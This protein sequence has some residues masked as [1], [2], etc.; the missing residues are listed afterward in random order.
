MS[1]D[2]FLEA[3]PSSSCHTW[4]FLVQ[5]YNIMALCQEEYVVE[6]SSLKF[7]VE[8]GFDFN[9]QYSCGVGY[10]RGNDKV[11]NSIYFMKD[12][13][14]Y[15]VVPLWILSDKL[16]II[17]LSVMLFLFVNSFVSSGSLIKTVDFKQPNKSK[18]DNYYFNTFLSL[19]IKCFDMHIAMHR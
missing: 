19:K 11:G 4:N 13:L 1:D 12:S 16:A 7:L 3:S 18:L 2:S 10:Y 6:P 15:R 17:N 9:K 8:H 14:E 5:T